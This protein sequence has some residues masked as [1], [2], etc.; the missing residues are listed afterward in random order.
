MSENTITV[1]KEAKWILLM[2]MGILLAL[3][4]F[5]VAVKADTTQEVV[6]VANAV[7]G[8]PAPLIEAIK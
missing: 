6:N 8:V 5:V 1:L 4:L 7:K 2:V 3:T